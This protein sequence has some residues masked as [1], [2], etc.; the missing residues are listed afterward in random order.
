M[1]VDKSGEY[2]VGTDANDIKEFLIAFTEDGYPI[3]EFRLAKCDC[4][5]DVFILE[6]DFDQGTARRT[7]AK[8][9]KQHLM[10]DSA[11]YWDESE[12]EEWSCACNSNTTNIGV[13]FALRPHEPDEEPDVKWIYVG[14]RC[15]KCGTLGCFADWKINYGPS[16]H[17]LG[18]V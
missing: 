6:A 13:G 5:S 10:C 11:E 1:T 9:K 2:W 7:C 8:C 14:C 15:S 12:P 4:G 17:L 3:K 18:Q 16:L